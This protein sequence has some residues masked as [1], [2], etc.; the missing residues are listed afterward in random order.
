MELTL[1]R[2]PKT[3]CTLGQLFYNGQEFCKT[4]EDIDRKLEVVGCH[5]KIPYLTAIPRGRYE[6]IIS[7]SDRFKKYMPLLLN[8]PCFDGIRIHSGNRTEDTEGCLIVGSDFSGDS[9]INSRVTFTKL[10]TML[11]SYEKKEKIWII[12]E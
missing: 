1:I 2:T 7:F 3:N 5:A 4:I 12:I 8:V 11:K 9:V 6:V 10:M